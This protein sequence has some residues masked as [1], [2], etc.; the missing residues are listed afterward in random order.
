L[1]RQG[2]ILA[3]EAFENLGRQGLVEIVGDPHLAF[4]PAGL[5]QGAVGQGYEA[6]LGLPALAMMISSPAA[7]RSTSLESEFLAS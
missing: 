4:P 7:A 5:A 1:F 3:L 6:S 2:S